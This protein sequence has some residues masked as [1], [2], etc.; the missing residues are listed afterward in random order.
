L[1]DP[2][3]QAGSLGASGSGKSS[4]GLPSVTYRLPKVT[5]V[6]WLIWLCGGLAFELSDLDNPF[7]R[8]FIDGKALVVISEVG[9]NIYNYVSNSL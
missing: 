1:P 6:N 3:K 8:D 9:L 2:E 5:Q 4:S 7:T